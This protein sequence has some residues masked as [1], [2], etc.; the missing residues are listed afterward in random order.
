MAGAGSSL[1]GKWVTKRSI[2][3]SSAAMP[4]PQASTAQPQIRARGHPIYFLIGLFGPLLM[5]YESTCHAG[6]S[7]SPREKKTSGEP[8]TKELGPKGLRSLGFGFTL[9]LSASR[10]SP[11]RGGGAIPPF[12]CRHRKRRRQ[13]ERDV[14]TVINVLQPGPIGIVEHKFTDAEIREAQVTVRSA[15]EKWRRNSALER[16]VGTGSF[17]K[18]K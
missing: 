4:P 11:R 9:L 5:W 16:N 15:V 13:V 10:S 14:E 1:P 18:S 2:A 8:L 12:S 17:H 7:A 6:R 3:A